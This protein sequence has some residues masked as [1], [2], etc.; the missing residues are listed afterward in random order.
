M[1]YLLKM[2]IYLLKMMIDL[3]K[4]MIYLLKL[5]IFHSTL[6]NWRVN[7]IDLWGIGTGTGPI[8]FIRFYGYFSAD[9]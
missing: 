2:V 6:N 1:I 8:G 5:V 4:M 9:F 3:L 7:T